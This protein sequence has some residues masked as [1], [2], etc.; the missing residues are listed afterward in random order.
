MFFSFNFLQLSLLIDVIIRRYNRRRRRVDF[1]LRVRLR[2]DS[3]ENQSDDDFRNIALDVVQSDVNFFQRQ[4]YL[5][6][7]D[8]RRQ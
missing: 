6:L 7:H 4:R 5:L 3:V 1:A 8:Q 2:R